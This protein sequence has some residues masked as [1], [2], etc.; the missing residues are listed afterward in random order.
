VVEKCVRVWCCM[1]VSACCGGGE[2]DGLS[3]RRVN[4]DIQARRATREGGPRTVFSHR[5]SLGGPVGASLV[6]VSS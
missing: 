3:S 1:V 2:G 4:V 5:V 6:V